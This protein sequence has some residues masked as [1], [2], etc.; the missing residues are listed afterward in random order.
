MIIER[1]KTNPEDFERGG[2][3]YRVTENQMSARDLEAYVE[4]HD[5]YVKEPQLM[6]A[7]LVALTAPEETEETMIRAYTSGRGG[8]KSAFTTTAIDPRSMQLISQ[9][10]MEQQRMHLE[11]HK[12]KLRY[13]Q[14]KAAQE[15][16]PRWSEKL[17]GMF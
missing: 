15:D 11:V 6:A 14:E 9:E 5:K 1:M 12:E 4:A 10:M 7:V 2:R 13:M 16:K 8:G 17:K 3:L